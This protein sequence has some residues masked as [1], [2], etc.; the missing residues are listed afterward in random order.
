MLNLD[1]NF[2]RNSQFVAAKVAPHKR[3]R[4]GVM[5]TDAVPKSASGKL[6]RRVQIQLDRQKNST[7]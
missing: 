6:L 4:G 7:K 5:F 3:L 2:I 1:V